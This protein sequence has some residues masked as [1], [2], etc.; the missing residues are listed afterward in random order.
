MGELAKQITLLISNRQYDQA[1]LV[2][3]FARGSLSADELFRITAVQ[4]YWLAV[5]RMDAEEWLEVNVAL[6]QLISLSEK[7][8]DVFFLNDARVRKI[9]CLKALNRQDEIPAQKA[10]LPADVEV[11]IGDKVVRAEDL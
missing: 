2:I 8:D 1:E 6:D 4:L 5:C 3:E 9:L 11:F 7:N 10:K